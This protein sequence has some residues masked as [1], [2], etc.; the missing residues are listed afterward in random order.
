[1]KYSNRLRM[2]KVCM[3]AAL[4]FLL[5]INV[6]AQI[7]INEEPKRLYYEFAVKRITKFKD[8]NNFRDVFHVNKFLMGKNRIMGNIA[9]NT[10]R[11]LISDGK[12]M[13]AEYRSAVSFFTR[14]RFLEEFSFN[15]NFFIDFNKRAT[16]RWMSDYSYTIGRY[17]WRPKKFNFGYENY[18]NNKYTDDLSE[19]AEKFLEGYYF[20]SY[21]H[22]LSDKA[23]KAISLDQS[24]SLKF[25]YFT[26]YAIKYRDEFNVTYGGIS[27]GKVTVGAAVRYTIYKNIYVEGAVYGYPEA[28]KRQPWDPDYT[29]GFGYFDWR[30]FRLSLT[31]G[32]W[33]INRFPWSK[34]Q[35][36]Y[37]G[38]GFIDGQ[39]RLVANWIW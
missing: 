32:N 27:N 5:Q 11:V 38:Y 15:T 9:Y 24:T 36:P 8:M 7:V 14:I 3:S 30:S 31:Y 28:Q 18:L 25:V 4:I 13:H 19:M 29:Y 6:V 35:N 23:T 34:D 12:E 20:L 17:N 26:R 22:N 39:F 10:G 1:M 37:V 21:S 16:A 33:A 2:E